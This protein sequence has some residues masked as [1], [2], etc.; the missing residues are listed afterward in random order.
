MFPEDLSL[1][2]KLTL[3]PSI[4]DF[5]RDTTSIHPS[6][7]PPGLNL[8]PTDEGTQQ[9]E[10]TPYGQPVRSLRNYQNCDTRFNNP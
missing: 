9:V 8:N 3:L 5:V 2:R 4:T 1:R 10:V 7:S 6:G